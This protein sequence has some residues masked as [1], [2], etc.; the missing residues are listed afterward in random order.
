[1]YPMP[2]VLA[3]SN[4]DGKPNYCTVAYVGIL[5]NSIISISLS[6]T[7]YTGAGIKQ[8]GTF[9]VNYPPTSLV[10]RADWCGIVSGRNE[11]KSA[12]FENFYG[13]LKT[14]PMIRECRLNM[15]CRLERIIEFPGHDVFAGEIVE[16]WCDEDCLSGAGVDFGKIDPMLFSSGGERGYWRLGERFADPF[17]AGKNFKP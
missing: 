17:S 10:E 14:A 7:R 13:T 8:N 2:T 15:E 6:K 1:M 11:D 12:V 9:S 16:T 5:D 4:I 3:G